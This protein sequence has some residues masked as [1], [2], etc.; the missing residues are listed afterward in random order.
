MNKKRNT[1]ILITVLVV[2]IG[3]GFLIQN[4]YFGK[5]GARAIIT[6]RGK[7]VAELNLN[8]PV[9]MTFD[10]SIGGTNTV[11]VKDGMISVTE[12]NCDNQV[13]VMSGKISHT[14]EVISCLPHALII[15]IQEDTPD[16]LDST[17]W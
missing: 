1:I 12:A 2:I 8:Q 5:S 6:Q 14:G 7:V 16:S 11:E 10:D 9:T 3:I 17:A 13:C 15:T 4:I